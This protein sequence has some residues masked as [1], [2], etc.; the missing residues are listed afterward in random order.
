MRTPLVS[1]VA[2]GCLALVLGACSPGGNGPTDDA[3]LSY[4]DSPLSPYFEKIGGTP[5]DE[6]AQEEKARQVEELVATCMQEQGFEYTPQDVSGMFMRSTEDEDGPAWDSLEWAEQYGYGMTTSSEAYPTDEESEWVDPNADYV[7]G[8][9]EGEQQAFYAALYGEPQ[10]EPTGEEGEE[11]EYDWTTAGCQGEAQHEIYEA[12][13][14]WSDPEYEELMDELSELYV[15]PAEDDALAEVRRAWA[16]CMADEGYDFATPDDAVNS[17]VEAQNEIPFDETTGTQ[18]EAAL[19]ELKTTE[20]ATAVADR[21][22]QNETKYAQKQLQ[23][24]FDR[25]EEFISAHKAELDAMVAK[26]ESSK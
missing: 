2:A 6:A 5:D 12:G 20:I 21:T 11:V 23:V 7:A 16:Q 19:D 10:D 4:E 14:I 25:E 17:I 18:D 3:S 24:Q 22:C 15:N 9:S 1:V 13:Q 8:M 26:V